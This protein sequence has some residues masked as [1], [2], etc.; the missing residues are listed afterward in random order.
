MMERNNRRAR[1]ALQGGQKIRAMERVAQQA[2]LE[3]PDMAREES[4][5]ETEMGQEAMLQRQGG[6]G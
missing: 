4:A 1:P 2:L 3:E 5:T 6:R